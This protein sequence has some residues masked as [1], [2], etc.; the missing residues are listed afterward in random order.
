MSIQY[1][2][3]PQNTSGAVN[4]P[5]TN[6]PTPLVFLTVTPS[7]NNDLGTVRANIGWQALTGTTPV[8]FKIWRGAPGTG[9][10]VCS[11]QDS[12]ES[13][14]DN[15]A[16]TDFSGVIS[17]LVSGQPVTFALTAE[18]VSAS[19]QARVIGPLTMTVFDIGSNIVSYYQFPNNVYG[20]ASIPVTQTPVPVGF[21]VIN[22]QPGQNVILRHS[23]CWIGTSGILPKVDMVFKIWRGAPVTGTL[24]ASADDSADVET[25]AV[26]SFSHV[27]S[28]FTS[29]QTVT[30]VITA[31]APDPGYTA[32]IVGALTTTGSTQQQSSFYT[33]PHNTTGSVSIPITTSAT[34]LASITV[35]ATPELELS[36]RAAVGWELP[37]QPSTRILFKIWRGAPNTGN[38]IYSALDSGEGH[39]DFRKVTALAHVDREFTTSGLVTYT[40]TA[41]LINPGTAATVIGP[42]T[43]TAVPEN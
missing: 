23:A 25:G 15:Y 42:L 37:P 26:T 10:L 31:E 13:S 16:T 29:A 8:I 28:G 43:F 19:I 32:S 7:S 4:I 2:T 9:Q 30:Y 5:I 36:L 3:L 33:L 24:I 11:V 1:Y 17:G 18:T 14:F 39:Y 40:L 41:E 20:A 6:T 38:L 12:A 34:P 27:D 22:V 21:I 35:Q